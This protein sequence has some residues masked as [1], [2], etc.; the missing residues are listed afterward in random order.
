MTG[1]MSMFLP[2]ASRSPDADVKVVGVAALAASVAVSHSPSLVCREVDD[3]SH[4]E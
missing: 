1:R 2:L 4:Q 3:G